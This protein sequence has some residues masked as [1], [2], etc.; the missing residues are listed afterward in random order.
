MT[1]LSPLSGSPASLENENTLPSPNPP[2]PTTTTTATSTAPPAKATSK[3]KPRKRVNTA[4]K[5]H[6]HNAIE[7]QRRETLN[8]KFLSL[9][10]L[11]PSLAAHRRP[12]KSAIVNG[13]IAHLTHQRDQRLLAA[14]LLRRLCSEHDTMLAEVNEWRKANGFAPKEGGSAWTDD[15]DE[16]CSVEKE[17]FGNFSNFDGEDGEEDDDN[18]MSLDHAASVAA[19]FGNV[20]GLITPRSSTDV[21]A[22]SHNP[23]LFGNMPVREARPHPA[24]LSN[25][26]NWTDDFSS[27]HLSNGNNAHLAFNAFMSD[28]MDQSSSDSPTNSQQGAVVTPPTSTDA[29]LYNH[30]PSPRSSNGASGSSDD[31]KSAAGPSSSG[32]NHGWNPTQ[33]LFLQ[34]QQAQLQRQQQ[35]AGV[36]CHFNSNMFSQAPVN[37]DAFTQQL[38]AGMFPANGANQDQVQQWRKSALGSLLPPNQVMQGGSQPSVDEL[39]VS[40]HLINLDFC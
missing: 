22:M 37:P 25:G 11:L 26:I 16:V 19:S 7:R 30:T 24:T 32:S 9:A 8:G 31:H 21:E 40:L 6:Q 35:H 10:R 5:R 4:E 29:L 27:F 2:V 1:T 20:G 17:V 39:R 18:E 15:V 14:K 12:S 28:Q 13:S 23:A 38:L 36:D 3:S 33:L 34:Q